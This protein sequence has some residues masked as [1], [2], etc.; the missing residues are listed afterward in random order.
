MSLLASRHR[1]SGKVSPSSGEKV[2]ESYMRADMCCDFQP[3]HTEE[4][5]VTILRPKVNVEGQIFRVRLTKEKLDEVFDQLNALRDCERP[6]A[7]QE[8]LLPGHVLEPVERVRTATEESSVSQLSEAA[9]N[10][11]NDLSMNSPRTSNE[12]MTRNDQICTSQSSAQ[13]AAITG[14]APALMFSGSV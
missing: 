12:P 7:L 14:S 13:P 11:Q 9:Q 8:L 10:A 2:T 6:A 5:E 1:D 4:G 3:P